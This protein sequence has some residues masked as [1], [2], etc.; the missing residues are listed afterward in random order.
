MNNDIIKKIV[1]ILSINEA[2]VGAFKLFER[3]IGDENAE[4]IFQNILTGIEEDGYNIETIKEILEEEMD[5]RRSLLVD[6][7]ISCGIDRLDAYRFNNE[8][9]AHIRAMRSY[10]DINAEERLNAL[11]Q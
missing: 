11:A 1:S 5:I 3:A 10:K 7:M 4:E 2:G 8:V 9:Y 6:E